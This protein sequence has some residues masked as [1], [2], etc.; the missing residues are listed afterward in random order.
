MLFATNV[1]R[2]I[3]TELL[4]NALKTAVCGIFLNFVVK[5]YD[6]HSFKWSYLA[7]IVGFAN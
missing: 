1:A 6:K 7:V 4:K 5:V 3:M 2:I